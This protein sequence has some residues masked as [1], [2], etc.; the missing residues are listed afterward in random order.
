MVVQRHQYT[1]TSYD[2]VQI[3]CTSCITRRPL[4]PVDNSRKGRDVSSLY[5]RGHDGLFPCQYSSTLFSISSKILVPNTP[6]IV[7]CNRRPIVS[8][9]NPRPLTFV[10]CPSGLAGVLSL[11][12]AAAL[13]QPASAGGLSPV[14]NA[15][16]WAGV[17]E[18]WREFP[19]YSTQQ[20]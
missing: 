9:P 3:P 6:A 16:K 8:I 2:K 15:D 18:K 13:S 14:G 4:A 1:R 19:T 10:P 12:G 5:R 17:R 20:Q 7:S 11:A